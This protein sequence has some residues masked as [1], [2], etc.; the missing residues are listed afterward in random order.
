M[1]K[2]GDSQ[3]PVQR[4]VEALELDALPVG[5]VRDVACEQHT[6]WRSCA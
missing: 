6:G 4:W 2:P 1:S 3:K 5:E